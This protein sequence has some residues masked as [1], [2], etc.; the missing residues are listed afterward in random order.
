MII[1]SW[2]Q[3]QRRLSKNQNRIIREIN[4]LV[5]NGGLY[6]EENHCMC[7][8]DHEE[9][10]ILLTSRDTWG[11]NIGQVI[12]SKC[13]LIRNRFVF[14]SESN[15]IF[16]ENYYRKL[17]NANSSYD[18]YFNMQCKRGEVFV[19]LLN[20]LSILDD[21]KEIAEFGCG[22]GGILVPFS[23][24][25]KQVI[26]V[27]LDNDFLEQGRLNGLDLRCGN[28]YEIIGDNTCDL[29]I[30][31]HVL[32]HLL[33]P[34]NEV[35]K[36]RSKIKHNKYLL[37][38]VPGLFND[39]TKYH[40]LIGFQIA[41]VFYF[42]KEWLSVFFEKSGFD[43]IY[44]DDW[45]TFVLKKN[46]DIGIINNIWD[47]SLIGFPEKI[48]KRCVDRQNS[49]VTIIIDNILSFVKKTVVYDVVIR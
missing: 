24:R 8:N 42:Y 2:R 30:M 10:D 49:F 14:S 43:I 23:K 5:D 27:D 11:I 31:S 9:N 40:P 17:Y 4:D 47:E 25:G 41:H 26:G 44:A 37:V 38:Q 1:K 28:F 18:T 12:C 48:Y 32:E 45:C 19:S 20:K 34:T 6:L 39:F 33:K 35:L 15:Q 21:I 36:I 7:G 16:Y 13:G 22:A 46:R 3:P 29:I